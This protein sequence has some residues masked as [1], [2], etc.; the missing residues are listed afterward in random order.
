M[1]RILSLVT[2]LGILLTLSP[3]PALAE[4]KTIY[5]APY[6]SSIR[7]AIR[8]S[9]PGGEPNPRGRIIYV[10]WVGFDDY[11]LNSLPNEWVPDWHDE[12]LKSGAM[13]VKMFAWYKILH[14]MKLD[15]WDYDLDNTTNFQTYR[16][17]NRFG[18]SDGAH[19]NTRNLAYTMPDGTIVELNYRAGYKDN[20]N[21][22]YRNAN[23]L[24]QWGS[25]YWANRGK[26]MLEILQWYYQGRQLQNIPGVTG[27]DVQ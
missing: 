21:W 25:Q 18:K 3:A 13:A 2:L 20:P 10:K 9:R 7:V 23:M 6:P 26:S 1:K 16:E 22:Q 8:E 4:H 5:N 19:F 11:V 15:G 27:G 14:P 24:A 12:S 17:G